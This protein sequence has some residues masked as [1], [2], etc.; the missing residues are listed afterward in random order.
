MLSRYLGDEPGVCERLACGIERTGVAESEAEL[1]QMLRRLGY[2][3]EEGA[4]KLR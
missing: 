3:A 2:L 4:D 1:D